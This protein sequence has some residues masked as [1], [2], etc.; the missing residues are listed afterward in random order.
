MKITPNQYIQT[1]IV[2]YPTLYAG[3]GLTYKDSKLRALDQLLNVLGNGIRNDEELAE[4]FSFIPTTEYSDKYHTND[5]YYGYK[6]F[7]EMKGF[8]FPKEPGI[9]CLDCDRK[10]YPDIIYWMKSSVHPFRPY[11]SFDEKYSTI[12]QCPSILD[13]GPDWIDAI[14][15]FYK[16]CQKWLVEHELEYSYAFPKPTEKET[17]RSIKEM[18]AALSKYD[19]NEKISEAYKREYHGDVYDFQV[20]R[21]KKEKARINKFLEKTI[22]MLN[23]IKKD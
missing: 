5:I 11:P 20:R 2:K 23:R 19:S 22:S 8:S 4:R 18:E 12:Y 6:E 21:W 17:D 3:K 16:E 15:F 7:E 13:F 10:N 1:C 9:D 14:L